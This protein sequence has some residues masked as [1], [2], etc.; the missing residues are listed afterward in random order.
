MSLFDNAIGR[1]FLWPGMQLMRRLRF[2]AKVT[3]MA[4]TLLV[5]LSWLIAQTLWMSHDALESTRLEARGAPLIGLTLD[6]VAQT[7][8]HRGLVNRALSGDASVAGDLAQNRVALKAAIGSLQS[9]L[10]QHPEF[11]LGDIWNPIRRVLDRLADG[12]VPPT[13]AQSFRLHTEQVEAMRRLLSR[14]AESSGLLLDP[15]GTSFHLMHLAV[16]PLVAWTE[17]L[18]QMRGRGAALLRK[19][20]V[21]ADDRAEIVAQSR[22]MSQAVASAEDIVAALV[23]SGETAPVGLSVA[24]ATARDYAQR[25][26]TTFATGAV[27]GDA[28]AYFA[29][30]TAATDQALGVGRAAAQRLQSML[31]DR[32]QRQQTLWFSQSAAGL[33]AVLGVAYIMLVYFRTSF[34]AIRVLRGSVTQLAAGDFATHVRLRRTDEMAE[35][36]D[37]LDAMSGRLSEMVADV[38]SSSSMVAQ[39][40]LSLSSDTRALSERTEAQAS[41]LEQTTASVQEL[42]GAV[43]KSAQGAEAA[44][45][46]AARV[47]SI[48]ESGGSAIQSAVSAMQDIQS[49]SSRVH[50]IVG[51]IEGISFQ[52]NILALNAAVEA[53][54]AGEQGR[55]FAVVAAEV[56]SLAQRSAESAREIKS[57]ITASADYVKTGVT[58]IGGASNTFAEI[59]H[60]IREVAQSVHQIKTSTAEQSS[61]LDQIAQAVHHIDEITQRNAQ[62][63]ES[64]LNSS[65]QLSARA[66]RLSSAVASFK[67]RQGSADEAHALVRKAVELYRRQGPAALAHITA[68]TQGFADRDMYV[69]AFDRNGVYRAFSGKNEKIGTSVRDIPGVD[70][71]KLIND[72][73][74]Q[75]AHGGGW[76]DYQ[77]SNPQSGAVDQKTSYVEPVTPDLV[78]GCGIYKS[79]G[80]SSSP[81]LLDL[82]QKGL[83]EQQRI[84]L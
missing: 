55:G 61:G 1:V 52:T 3:V 6:V 78:L 38:R 62:M 24:L 54:R 28:A 32:A 18:G 50:E 48:A 8:K 14:A 12:E 42:S 75:A 22:V 35:I 16:E 72:A 11:E 76:V 68:A 13:A 56:R 10:L 15:E 23:R 43:R 64:A 4:L 20:E 45:G 83:R 37:F 51:V 70:G 59:V 53:A 31:E 5:P 27:A 26:E 2:P 36:G 66:E 79:R 25:A 80:A 17:A 49:S 69:F 71:Q 33:A 40:G 84:N 74:E 47:Q 30:G 73:F 19:G 29:A 34:G 82:P 57:L 60:G 7:Q 39:A 41:S 65:S 58:Q 9:T 81:M 46:M 63:V 67:L 21:S 44:S 77:F